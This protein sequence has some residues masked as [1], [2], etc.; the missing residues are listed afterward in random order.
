[1]VALATIALHSLCFITYH[2]P[3]LSHFE[4]IIK[5]SFSVYEAGGNDTI[6]GSYKSTSF[7]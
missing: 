5:V 7:S 2:F 6:L 4:D 1:M 3:T